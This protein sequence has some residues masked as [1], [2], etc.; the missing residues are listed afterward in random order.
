ML[1]HKISFNKIKKTE[2]IPNIFSYHKGMKL[3]IN[4]K[5]NGNK[6]KHKAKNTLQNRANDDGRNQRGK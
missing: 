1:G 4:Y 5:K 6:Q 3:E 2:L